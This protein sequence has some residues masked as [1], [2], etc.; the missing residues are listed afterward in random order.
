LEFVELSYEFSFKLRDIFHLTT[1]SCEFKNAITLM[2]CERSVLIY[3]IGRI[4]RV[5]YY[6]NIF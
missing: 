3:L 4:D 1:V 6:V 2:F 5:E